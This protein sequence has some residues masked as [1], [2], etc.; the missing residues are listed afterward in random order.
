M[1]GIGVIRF[2][3]LTASVDK[4]QKK[5]PSFSCEGVDP[6]RQQAQPRF[7]G[8]LRRRDQKYLHNLSLQWT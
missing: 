6:I 7:R 1:Y 3:K 4:W 2:G 8:R 5:K